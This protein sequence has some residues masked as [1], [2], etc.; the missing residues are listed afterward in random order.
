LDDA[1]HVEMDL[2]RGVHSNPSTHQSILHFS[3][4]KAATQ[5]VRSILAQ[6]AV[7]EGMVPVHIHDYAFHTSFPYLDHLSADEMGSYQHIFKPTG[8][9]YS[10]FG[11]MIEG[12]PSLDDF[13][14]VLMVRDPRDVLVSKYYSIAYSHSE[15][16]KRGDKYEAF[17]EQRTFAR[18]ASVDEYV[19]AES[20]R[21]RC[22]YQ[23][24]IDLLVER[25]SGYYLTKYEDMVADF[26][27]WLHSLLE[28]CQI[29]PSEQLCRTLIEKQNRAIPEEED[30]DKHL[31][32][33]IAGDHKNKL[34]Q[35]TIE[36]LD[37]RFGSVL[38]SFGYEF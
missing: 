4:N 25:H 29:E 26:P 30:K 5:Y 28:Y 22:I 24:Y 14:I 21:I 3:V 15:P 1:F 19:L 33:G 17:M 27:R 7:E 11:G 6:C 35:R 37:S 12:I 34:T 38:E 8:Y 36:V 16:D 18:G 31:R 20:E 32:K 13:L 2:I 10:A 9:L 23:R